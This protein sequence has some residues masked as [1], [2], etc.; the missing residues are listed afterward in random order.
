ME[1]AADIAVNMATHHKKVHKGPIHSPV[2]GRTDHLPMKVLS[3]SYV[4]PAD[5]ISA[6]GEGNSMAGFKIAKD[7]FSGGHAPYHSEGAPYHSEG[8]PYGVSTPHRATGGAVPIVAAG[9][10][11]VIPPE[12]VVR[13]GDGSLDAGHKRLDLFV[14]KFRAKTIKTLSNLKGPAK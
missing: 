6:M 9:G 14:R 12:D 10:E 11:F 5:I 2:A 3:G 1:S 4:I 8:L 7:I 13:I